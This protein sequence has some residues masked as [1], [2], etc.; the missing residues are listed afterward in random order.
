MDTAQQALAPFDVLAGTWR[1][2]ATHPMFDG[3]VHGRTTFE[4]L[5]GRRFL[6]VRATQDQEL[7]PD[8]VGVIGL[9]EDGSAL[10]QEHFDERG[11][12]RTYVTSV[13]E[14]G[15]W[16]ASRDAPGFDQRLEATTS[17][18]RIDG[19]WQLAETPGAWRDDLR[20]TYFR[21]A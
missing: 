4:W 5:P 6:V 16:R 13:D 8:A 2:E 19:L 17:A 3:V 1:T 15:T 9:T 20:I 14:Q 11:V 7:F 10:T 18:D 21:E 12:R